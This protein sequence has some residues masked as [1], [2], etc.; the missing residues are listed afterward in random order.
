MASTGGT[1]NAIRYMGGTYGYWAD[2]DRDYNVE[3][4]NE[5]RAEAITARDAKCVT[6]GG[7]SQT[8]NDY[9]MYYGP[10]IE[11]SPAWN[12]DLYKAAR[13]RTGLAAAYNYWYYVHC[14]VGVDLLDCYTWTC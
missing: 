8:Y 12:H 4:W 3:A 9:G 7:C 10:S 13:G 11:F 14:K 1:I 2:A 5:T 6:E